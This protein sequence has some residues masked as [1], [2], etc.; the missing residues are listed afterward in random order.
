MTIY[1]DDERRDQMLALETK[2]EGVNRHLLHGDI[3]SYWKVE[4]ERPARFHQGGGAAFAQLGRSE[5]PV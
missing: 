1:R 3:A 5:L 4:T 2:V